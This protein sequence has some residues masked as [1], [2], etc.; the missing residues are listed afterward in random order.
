MK[1]I[2]KEVFGI[3][4]DK[5]LA[6][7]GNRALFGLLIDNDARKFEAFFGNPPAQLMA[8]TFYD[9]L[10]GYAVDVAKQVAGLKINADVFLVSKKLL[11]E[12]DKEFDPIVLHE[13]IHMVID[14]RVLPDVWKNLDATD[15]YHGNKLYK[16]TDTQNE[17]RTRHTEQF[18]AL[19]AYAAQLLAE[20]KN[21]YEDR[22]DVI[23]RAMRA[24]VKGGFRK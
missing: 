10:S 16:K 8:A 1:S 15:Q 6:D 3:D 18:C 12:D 13:V 9:A 4:F 19:P 23:N 24:D 2:C 7:H 11:E 17:K 21:T 14:S 20:L 22:W 5:Y